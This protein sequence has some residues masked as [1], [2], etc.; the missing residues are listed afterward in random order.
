MKR[1]LRQSLRVLA[2]LA[3]FAV[4]WIASVNYLNSAIPEPPCQD[5]IYLLACAARLPIQLPLWA[6]AVALL[7]G[8]AA[9]GAVLV[10]TRPL[11][12]GAI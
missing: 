1:L 10:L 5:V 2:A 12:R 9:A 3:A 7:V 11:T 4:V 8:A 6:H